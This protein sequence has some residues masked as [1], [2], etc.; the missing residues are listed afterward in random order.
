MWLAIILLVWS[1]YSALAQTQ[2]RKC[3]ILEPIDE[4]ALTRLLEIAS[5]NHSFPPGGVDTARLV[6]IYANRIATA[7]PCP[8][9]PPAV[10][11][12]D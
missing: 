1:V 9:P 10:Q 6:T 2:V 12:N 5:G 11:K 4:Q 8:P 7:L 3:L